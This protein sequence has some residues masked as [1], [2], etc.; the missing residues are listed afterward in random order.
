MAD[1]LR[2]H[3]GSV[4]SAARSARSLLPERDSRP[5]K[6]HER[7]P[8]EMDLGPA[9]TQGAVADRNCRGR[10]LHVALRLSWAVGAFCGRLR[11]TAAMKTKRALVVCIAAL[12]V[13]GLT[14][15]QWHLNKAVEKARAE[16][17]RSAALADNFVKES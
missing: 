14:W 4:S 12:I 3:L 8:R 9:Q 13:A 6:R 17:S 5:G 11:P 1:G 10:N 7:K 16:M 15:H 2:R